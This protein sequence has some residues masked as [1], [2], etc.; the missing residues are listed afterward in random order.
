LNAL[1][2]GS[3]DS[4]SEKCA[5]TGPLV[6]Q[7]MFVQLS[8]HFDVKDGAKEINNL[9]FHNFRYISREEPKISDSFILYSIK[10]K[11]FYPVK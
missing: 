5:A 4:V 8:V 11:Y 2:V 6:L 3:P 9:L 7:T 10:A 1:R